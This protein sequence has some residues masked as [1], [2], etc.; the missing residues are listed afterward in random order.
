MKLPGLVDYL[1]SLANKGMALG[2]LLALLLPQL[3]SCIL[4]RKLY[5]KIALIMV[6]TLP[7]GE[8]KQLMYCCACL[9]QRGTLITLCHMFWVGFDYRSIQYLSVPST[10]ALC[11]Q[12]MSKSLQMREV[13]YV[14][15]RPTVLLFEHSHALQESQLELLLLKCQT[16]ADILQL[17]VQAYMLSSLQLLCLANSLQPQRSRSPV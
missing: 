9:Q 15:D 1:G 16:H 14:V 13:M 10:D 6:K 4:A 5:V 7:L 8:R 17:T 11:S 12:D 2:P 3:G